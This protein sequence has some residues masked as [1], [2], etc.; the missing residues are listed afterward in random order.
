MAVANG[1]DILLYVEGQAIGCLTS[2]NFSSTNT[3][4]DV[5]CKD[6]NGARQILSGSNQAEFAFNGFFNP[7]AGYG[8]QDLVA[9]H[10]NKTRVWVKMMLDG[11]DSLTITCYARM[12][13]LDWGADLNA[14]STFSGTFTV[15]GLWTYSIT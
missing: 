10:L 3:E 11:S 7:A 5:T 14:G 4:I 8:F 2:N 12:N 13:K 1:N 6:N 15:D 9:V